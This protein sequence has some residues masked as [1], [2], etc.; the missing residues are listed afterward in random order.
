MSNNSADM[1]LTQTLI[2][3]LATRGIRTPCNVA[4]HVHGGLAT[5][6]GTVTQVHQKIA[7]TSV[8]TG[9]SGIK[10]VVN[11]IVVKAMERRF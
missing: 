5:L 1:K 11:N 8:A 10:R 7:A 3:K 4:V 9:V 2:N 6:T